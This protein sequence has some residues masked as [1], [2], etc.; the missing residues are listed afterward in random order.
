MKLPTHILASLATCLLT[1]FLHTYLRWSS[2]PTCFYAVLLSL[3]D[4]RLFSQSI[5][6]VSNWF[7]RAKRALSR[8]NTDYFYFSDVVLICLIIL[9]L[10]LI[11]FWLFFLL[12]LLILTIVVLLLILLFLTIVFLILNLFYSFVRRENYLCRNSY[13]SFSD[14]SSFCVR[15]PS[16]RP[17][18]TGLRFPSLPV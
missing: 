8:S 10:V 1:Y 3:N 14:S 17:S 11:I 9:L 2:F 5:N 13:Y 16:P 7:K 18:M 12:S 15:R 6:M 4:F